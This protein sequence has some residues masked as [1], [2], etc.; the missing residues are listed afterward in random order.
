MVRI[1][2]R[3]RENPDE[4]LSKRGEQGDLERRGVN[5]MSN[6]YLVDN[7]DVGNIYIVRSNRAG[8]IC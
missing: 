2:S 3:L 8:L 5:S 4:T 7:T 6:I 1:R